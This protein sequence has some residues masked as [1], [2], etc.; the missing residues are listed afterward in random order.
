VSVPAPVS[1]IAES[2]GFGEFGVRSSE[3]GVPGPRFGVPSPRFGVP[4]PGFGV[5]C[6]GFGVPCPGFGVP[7]PGFG[8]PGSGVGARRAG[9]PHRLRR[10]SPPNS[11]LRTPNSE[12]EQIPPRRRRG[13]GRV[14]ARRQARDLG[15]D[16]D[17]HGRQVARALDGRRRARCGPLVR[18]GRHRPRRQQRRRHQP[19][20]REGL[21]LHTRTPDSNSSKSPNHQITKSPNHQI[22][23]SPDHQIPCGRIVRAPS[24]GSRHTRVRARHHH[25]HSGSI[26]VDPAS[27][28]SSL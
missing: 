11:E 10:P 1:A 21:R 8:V 17:R 26:P 28:E 2:S 16:F 4:S 14:R 18:G 9:G 24:F 22:N 25:H 15:L 27:W 13:R 5:P 20:A 6:P 23:R 19:R 7:R 12:L 3:F